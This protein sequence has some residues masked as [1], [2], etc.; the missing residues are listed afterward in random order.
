MGVRPVSNA[1]RMFVVYD[2]ASDAPPGTV[3]VRGRSIAAGRDVPD[4]HACFFTSID[5][6]REFLEGTGLYRMPR[7]PADDPSI[8]EVW[9]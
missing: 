2:Q 3:V 4:P 1:L 9:L 8:L 7:H 5:Q 6:A